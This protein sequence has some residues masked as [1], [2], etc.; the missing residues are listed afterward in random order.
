M[1]LK[2]PTMCNS[3]RNVNRYNINVSVLFYKSSRWYILTFVVVSFLFKSN[4]INA[5]IYNG[6]LVFHVLCLCASNNWNINTMKL[7]SIIF[8]HIFVYILNK[9]IVILY[10]A[11]IIPPIWAFAGCFPRGIKTVGHVLKRYSKKECWKQCRLYLFISPFL[12]KQF[13]LCLVQV[14]CRPNSHFL[15]LNDDHGNRYQ[16]TNTQKDNQHRQ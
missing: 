5:I 4:I 3:L 14:F 6:V 15:F 9:Y 12:S 10:E 2:T 8:K 11:H 1:F 13:S 7:S 16:Q